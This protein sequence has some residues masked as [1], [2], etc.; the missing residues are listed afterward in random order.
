LGILQSIDHRAGRRPLVD[1]E[2]GPLWQFFEDS[3]AWLVRGRYGS[4]PWLTGRRHG[5]AGR[6]SALFSRRAHPL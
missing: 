1:R 6:C 4:S 2:N 3:Y 5:D